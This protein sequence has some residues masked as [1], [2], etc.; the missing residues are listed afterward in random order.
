MK[1][2]RRIILS[3]DTLSCKKLPYVIAVDFDGTLCQ[4]GV[5]PHVGEPNLKLF[6][7]LIYMQKEQDCRIVLWTCR[8]AM[9]LE[10][11]VDFC[12]HYG[13]TFD[14]VN[15]NIKELKEYYGNNPR[16]IFAQKYIDDHA[17]YWKYEGDE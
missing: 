12:K 6:K 9:D 5:W 1:E 16:K 14:A 7:Y 8:D 4:P 13:L 3:E 11:A 17:V 15:D 10:I 2:W